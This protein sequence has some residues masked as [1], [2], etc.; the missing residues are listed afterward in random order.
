MNELVL[1]GILGIASTALII[2]ALWPKGE[3]DKEALKRRMMGKRGV[4]ESVDIQKQA[5]ES[6]AQKMLARVAPLAMKPVMPK[7]ESEVSILRIKLA[8][9][10]FRQQ[11]APTL[12]L[13]SKT[14]CGVGFA[15]AALALQVSAGKP[16][17]DVIT[18]VIGGGGVGFM[19][20]NA[21]LWLAKR[22]RAKKIRN[23]LADSMDLLVIS[24]ESGLALDA[25]IQRVGDEM[26][27]VHPELSEEMR[28]VSYEGQMGIPRSEALNNMAL[29]T[30][31]PE[32]KSLVALITQ[33]ERFGT[34]VAKALRNQADAMR[35]KRKQAAEEAAQ[36]TTVK[37]MIPLMLFI[38]PAIFVVLIGPAVLN[39]I[40]TYQANPM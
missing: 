6:T 37:L 8:N 33:A 10:G 5:K 28:I 32:V 22:Q 39:M 15:L 29:R 12:F 18:W 26:H 38:F 36:K 24:V 30:G 25:A 3:I 13:S 14:V 21:W 7:D 35:L 34:S 11:N 27:V 19:L 23:G 1:L 17:M 31:L 9:A 4:D 16:A 2:Y 40:K 20:P